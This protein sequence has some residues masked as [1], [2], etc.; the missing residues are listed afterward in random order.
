MSYMSYAD[1]QPDASV[2]QP[3]AP[4]S[5]PKTFA[6][7]KQLFT[8]KKSQ[9]EGIPVSAKAADVLGPDDIVA[10]PARTWQQ[11]FTT[12]ASL[13]EGI[14]AELVREHLEHI[15]LTDSSKS[16]PIAQFVALAAHACKEASSRPESIPGKQAAQSAD[17]VFKEC[18]QASQASVCIYLKQCTPPQF[19]HQKITCLQAFSRHPCSHACI[20]SYSLHGAEAVSVC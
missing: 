2:K 14:K 19:I 10:G 16:T 13:E 3:E 6:K 15:W 11:A 12:E 17:S 8:G 18:L 9:P 5:K 7:F 4:A 20:R 1:L